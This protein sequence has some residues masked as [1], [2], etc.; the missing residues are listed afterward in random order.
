MLAIDVDQFLLHEFLV[1]VIEKVSPSVTC[2]PPSIALG[3]P[4]RLLEEKSR[5]LR[6]H[7]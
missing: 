1:D 6:A 7:F 4:I 5:P 2:L 3:G